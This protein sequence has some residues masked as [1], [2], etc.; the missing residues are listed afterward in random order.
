MLFRKTKNWI[1]HIIN[2]I[3]QSCSVE[4]KTCFARLLCTYFQDVNKM[5]TL[6]S[7]FTEIKGKGNMKTENKINP[8]L[9]ISAHRRR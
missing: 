2:L 4:S 7:N 9:A 1:G 3:K 8:I 5:A 6:L